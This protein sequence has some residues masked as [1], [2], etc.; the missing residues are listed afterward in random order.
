MVE[1]RLLG[2]S[3]TD[4][5]ARKVQNL[6]PMLGGLE[7]EALLDSVLNFI[8]RLFFRSLDLFLLSGG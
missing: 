8:A 4:L 5:S 1:C 3:L 6:Y 7:L 2:I